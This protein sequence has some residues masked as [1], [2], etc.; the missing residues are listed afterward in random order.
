MYKSTIGTHLNILVTLFLLIFSFSAK[1]EKNGF[2]NSN[3]MCLSWYHF[4]SIKLSDYTK[5]RLYE[6]RNLNNLTRLIGRKNKNL[7]SNSPKTIQDQIFSEVSRQLTAIVRQMSDKRPQSNQFAI[8][9]IKEHIKNSQYLRAKK[10]NFLNIMPI[11]KN[12]FLISDLN[13]SALEQNR[14]QI[15]TWNEEFKRFVKTFEKALDINTPFDRAVHTISDNRV[16]IFDSLEAE[17]TIVTVN[18]FQGSE[19][20]SAIVSTQSFSTYVDTVND[21]PYFPMSRYIKKIH[22]GHPVFLPQS[23]QFVLLGMSDFWKAD[24]D[25][26]EAHLNGQKFKVIL[27]NKNAIYEIFYL[28]TPSDEVKIEED[29]TIVNTP[30]QKR[31]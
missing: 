27:A 11:G 16:A 29:L 7:G 24:E 17:V 6:I 25:I 5:Q 4:T 15:V 13:N 21:D 19:R 28:I 30:K 23:N 20:N 12:S 10:E 1:A 26:F 8:Q 22:H 18:S 14:I 31:Q 9:S 2:A 3:L